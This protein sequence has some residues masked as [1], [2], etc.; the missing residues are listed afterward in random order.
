[1]KKRTVYIIVIAIALIAFAL[2]FV[3]SSA[4]SYAK[5]YKEGHKDGRLS[6]FNEYYSLHKSGVV[7]K[8]KDIYTIA[9]PPSALVI[10][11]TIA[12][13]VAGNTVCNICHKKS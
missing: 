4:K 6:L 3:G 5:G 10:T 11:E 8:L 12:P 13:I 9:I 2:G 1:M 7:V